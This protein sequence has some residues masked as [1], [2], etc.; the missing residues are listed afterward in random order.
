M[1]KPR[2]RFNTEGRGDSEH[3]GHREEDGN[4][5][6]GEYEKVA[7]T[8]D[9]AGDGAAVGEMAKSRKR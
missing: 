3:R 7:V 5:R 1:G 8:G 9:D 4:Q 6:G 2:K